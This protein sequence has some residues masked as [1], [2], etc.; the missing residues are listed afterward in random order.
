MATAWNTTPIFASLLLYVRQAWRSK[1]NGKP[2]HDKSTP[3]PGMPSD[4]VSGDNNAT[5]YEKSANMFPI[6]A[7]A[8][9]MVAS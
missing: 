8:L 5:P 2:T 4:G 6:T 1:N 7:S 9:V 3:I